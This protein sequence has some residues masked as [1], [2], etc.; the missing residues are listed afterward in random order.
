MSD[1]PNQSPEPL[2]SSK[3]ERTNTETNNHL[4]IAF[5]IVG[6]LVGDDFIHFDLNDRLWVDQF[7][8]AVT[9]VADLLWEF[10]G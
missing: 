3:N 9:E 2:D 8:L 6:M 5:A 10:H 7:E 1:T 4:R